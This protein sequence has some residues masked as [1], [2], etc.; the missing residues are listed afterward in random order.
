MERMGMPMFPPWLQAF[1]VELVL[2]VA[3]PGH[4]MYELSVSQ[5]VEAIS[6]QWPSGSLNLMLLG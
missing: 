1:C 5:E 6:I 3:G 2:P 4:S